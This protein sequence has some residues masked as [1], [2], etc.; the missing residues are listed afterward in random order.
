MYSCYREPS[1][2]KVLSVLMIT[3][4]Y[5]CTDGYLYASVSMHALR[6]PYSL[7]FANILLG[8]ACLTVP[9][10]GLYRLALYPALPGPCFSTFSHGYEASCRLEMS[11]RQSQEEC[12]QIWTMMS[13]F[14]QIMQGVGK[15][16]SLESP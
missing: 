10:M 3:Y 5:V 11:V 8:T 7:R 15:H 1:K 16:Q 6:I 2:A 4:C 12:W 14:V 13:G 9:G